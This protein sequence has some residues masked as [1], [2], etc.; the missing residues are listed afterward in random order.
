M[1]GAGAANSRTEVHRDALAA[2]YRCGAAYGQRLPMLPTALERVAAACTENLKGLSTA[3]PR[4]T[5]LGLESGKASELFGAERKEWL[6]GLLHAL[7]WDAH[8]LVCVNYD[9]IYTYVDIALGGDGSQQPFIEPRPLSRIET[10]IAQTFVARFAAALK[11]GFEP[12]AATLFALDGDMG[13]V[14]PDRLG[15]PHAPV[16]IARYRLEAGQCSGELQLAIPDAVLT[17]LKPA[18]ARPPLGRTGTADPGWSQK[19][20][21]EINR[22]QLTMHAVLEDRPRTLAEVASF[23][24][25]QILPLE[26]T[27]RSPI[28][29][30]CNGEPLLWGEVGQSN[31]VYTLR[32]QGFVDREQEF[33]DDIL[34]G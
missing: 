11:I 32:V 23:R 10:R 4:V 19:I 21:G 18:F 28:R 5:Y 24:V 13:S 26:A 17:A 2:I 30:D 6:T 27:A 16:A 7:A 3:Q 8:V 31:G 33:M 9:L 14:N 22:T 25:G 12:Y 15:G 20:R 29:I 34:S 1:I